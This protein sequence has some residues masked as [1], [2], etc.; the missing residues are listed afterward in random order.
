MEVNTELIHVSCL[1]LKE[2]LRAVVK[3]TLVEFKV[4]FKMGKKGKNNA[5]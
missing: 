2:E 4:I 3:T 5:F 1:Q